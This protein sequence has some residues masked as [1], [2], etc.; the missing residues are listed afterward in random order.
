MLRANFILTYTLN[1]PR[2]TMSLMH[3]LK[4]DQNLPLSIKMWQKF[5]NW[6]SHSCSM[7]END[8]GVVVLKSRNEAAALLRKNWMVS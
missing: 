1:S 3:V 5:K 7:D 6:N 2:N 4:I 8:V